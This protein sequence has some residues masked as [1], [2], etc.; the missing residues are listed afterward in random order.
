MRLDRL[1]GRICGK[2][3]REVRGILAKGTVEVNGKVILN[4]RADVSEF[5]RLALDGKVLQD[6]RAIYVMLNKSAGYL[7]ATVDDEHPTVMELLGDAFEGEDLHIAGRLDRA[8]T[9]LLLLTNDGN[10]SQALTLPEMEHGKAYL[11]ETAEPIAPE[12]AEQFSRGI[13]FGYEDITT[14]ASELEILGAQKARLTIYEGKYHQVKRMFHAVGNR[15]VS[16]H[17][18]RVGEIVLDPGLAQGEWR[19]LRE[20]EV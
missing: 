7:S 2:G 6:R 11:V 10:W 17:R 18:E 4:G 8:S 15:V 19:E 1:L 13:Y 3:R 16:L 20:D 9:G 5:D 14:G 12:T